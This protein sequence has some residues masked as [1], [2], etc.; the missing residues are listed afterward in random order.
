MIAAASTNATIIVVPKL[1]KK[2]PNPVDIGS[3]DC[4]LI[5][6]PKSMHPIANA[7]TPKM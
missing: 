5:E 3:V 4:P 6:F 7:I 1:I 2:F